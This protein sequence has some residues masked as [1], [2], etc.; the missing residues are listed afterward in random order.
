MILKKF[1]KREVHQKTLSERDQ[2][3]SPGVVYSTPYR[4]EDEKTFSNTS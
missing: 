2:D 4:R 3:H 1:L